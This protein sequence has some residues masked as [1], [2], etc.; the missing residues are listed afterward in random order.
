MSSLEMMFGDGPPV[1]PYTRP[2]EPTP[3]GGQQAPQIAEFG[4]RLNAFGEKVDDDD[5]DLSR[6]AD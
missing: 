3:D 1:T 5:D 4:Q 6:T 2:I